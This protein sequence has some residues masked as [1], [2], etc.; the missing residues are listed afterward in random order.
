MQRIWPCVFNECE[1]TDKNCFVFS[2]NFIGD[3]GARL[4]AKSLCINSKLRVVY[5]D[6]NNTMAQGFSDVAAALKK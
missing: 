6:N 3:M 4:L 5:W 1:N 2:G